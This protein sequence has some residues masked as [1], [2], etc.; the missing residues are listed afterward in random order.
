[1][2]SGRGCVESGD[3]HWLVSCPCSHCGKVQCSTEMEEQCVD[4]LDQL[5]PL[6]PQLLMDGVRNIWIVKPGALSRGR[7]IECMARLEPIQ[8]LVCGSTP[9][10]E[11]KWI[12]QKYIGEGGTCQGCSPSPLFSLLLSPSPTVLLRTASTDSQYKV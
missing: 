2:E 7:G 12:V 9:K 3:P 11:G 6:L 1:M 5:R 10:K 8:D 4:L